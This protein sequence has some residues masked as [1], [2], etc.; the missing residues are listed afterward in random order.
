[1]TTSYA[2]DV[3]KW[4]GHEP[5]KGRPNL[6]HTTSFTVADVVTDGSGNIID[7]PVLLHKP[8]FGRPE[9]FLRHGATEQK[10]TAANGEE[11]VSLTRCDRCALVGVRA[12]CE[13]VVMERVAADPI[14]SA[15]FDDWSEQTELH[16]T[17]RSYTGPIGRYWTTFR[18]A[19]AARGPFDSVNDAAVAAHEAGLEE[20]RRQAARIKKRNQR[21]T[22]Q[23][24]GQAPTDDFILAALAERKR[25]YNV[26]ADLTGD[27]S[28]PRFAAKLPL[29]GCEITA[30][31][32]LGDLLLRQVGRLAGAADIARWLVKNRRT[33]GVAMGRLRV[34]VYDDLR[35]VSQLEAT[36]HGPAIWAAFDPDA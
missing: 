5:W 25:R 22:R 26:L 17:E 14:I 18:E 7:M 35:R 33:H 24:N 30:D 8:C 12:A 9:V 10:F 31:V 11:V 36:E 6:K 2:D 15:A 16:P 3:R 29:H 34:R 19:V 1:M 4:S 32:W 28:A 23:Y 20:G 13:S 27:P 21:A